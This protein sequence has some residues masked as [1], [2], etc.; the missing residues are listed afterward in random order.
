MADEDEILRFA[1]DDTVK[2]LRGWVSPSIMHIN[3]I[4]ARPFGITDGT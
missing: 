3:I 4:S 2:Q 1:Q